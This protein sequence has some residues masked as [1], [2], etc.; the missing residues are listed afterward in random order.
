LEEYTVIDP[1]LVRKN[2]H[3]RHM[4]RIDSLQVQQ[5]ISDEILLGVLKKKILEAIPVQRDDV[6]SYY[7]VNT[8]IIDELI[9]WLKENFL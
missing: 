9:E 6:P 2:D 8:W 7:E 1:T 5:L 4:R 3:P